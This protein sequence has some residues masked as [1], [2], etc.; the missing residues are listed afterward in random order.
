MFGKWNVPRSSHFSDSKADEKLTWWS[1][2]W[3]HWSP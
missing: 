3:L 1:Y 2:P